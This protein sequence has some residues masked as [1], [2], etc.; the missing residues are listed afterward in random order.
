M[1]NSNCNSIIRTTIDNIIYLQSKDYHTDFHW[2]IDLHPHISSIFRPFDMA[3]GH[4]H[5][6]CKLR[7]NSLLPY[8]AS[9][10]IHLFLSLSVYISFH[11]QRKKINLQKFLT[12][13]HSCTLLYA[14][15]KFLYHYVFHCSEQ[16]HIQ[17][18]MY[19]PRLSAHY[20][21]LRFNRRK[22]IF[23]QYAMSH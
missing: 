18:H 1:S 15:Y 10:I 16:Q 22:Q 11:Q 20:N 23:Y 8:W 5:C 2:C 21:L 6:L 9:A 3:F 19:Q 13:H 12:L 17:Q 4:T 14:L 7:P